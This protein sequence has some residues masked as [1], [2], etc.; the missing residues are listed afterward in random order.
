MNKK[1][2]L[3]AFALIVML[4]SIGAT[5][6]VNAQTNPT[7]PMQGG[8]GMQH[9]G[10]GMGGHMGMRPAAFGTVTAIN[11][12]IITVTQ[13]NPKDSTTVT[14]TVDATNA[15]VSKNR[16]SSTVSAIVVGDKVMVIG[17]TNGTNITATSINDGMMMRTGGRMNDTNEKI[18]TAIQN[19]PAGNGQPIVGGTVTAISGSSI[20]ITNSAGVTYSIDTTTAKFNKANTTAP[21]ITN[22]VIGDTV[23]AQGN[24]NGTSMTAFSVIDNGPATQPTGSPSAN[25]PGFFGKVGGFFKHIFGF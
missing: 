6:H 14:Y 21:T 24:I 4:A 22:V 16:T 23:V 13:T 10:R 12:S 17:T 15:Q 25:H 18:G 11:G 5:Q 20:T 3:G 9:K 2:Y 7:A 19:L 8:M 1:K